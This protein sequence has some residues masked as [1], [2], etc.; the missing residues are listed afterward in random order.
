[1]KNV[2][3]LLLVLSA[4]K[5][6]AATTFNT[7]IEYNNF[8]VGEVDKVTAA[9]KNVDFALTNE[10]GTQQD[11]W[12]AYNQLKNQCASSVKTVSEAEMFG[13]ATYF[14][15]SCI[16]LLTMYQNFVNDHMAGI[17]TL[18]MSESPSQTDLQNANNILD[19]FETDEKLY[20]SVFDLCQTVY[21]SEY[22]F[23]LADAN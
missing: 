16:D 20:D 8:L 3:I 5:L 22:G 7:A 13:D 6:F 18:I 1:M 17:L 14:K 2:I 15:T 23:E 4:G 11:V 12:D 10:A 19:S 21:A 9:F